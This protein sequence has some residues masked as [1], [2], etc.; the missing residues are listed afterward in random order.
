MLKY[1]DFQ[2]MS[3]IGAGIS[4][5]VFYGRDTITGIAFAQLFHPPLLRLNGSAYPG[6]K[7]HNRLDATGKTIAAYYFVRGLQDTHSRSIVHFL[8]DGSNRIGICDFFVAADPAR[9]RDAVQQQFQPLT[10][11]FLQAQL[12]HVADFMRQQDETSKKALRRAQ[13]VGTEAQLRISQHW[14]QNETQKKDEEALFA[15]QVQNGA[16]EQRS[17]HAARCRRLQEALNQKTKECWEQGLLIRDCSCPSPREEK[18]AGA[19]RGLPEGVL[20]EV[21]REQGRDGGDDGG[22]QGEGGVGAGDVEEAVAAL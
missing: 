9:R 2:E 3:P 4:A 16:V 18:G 14:L 7:Q 21:H 5:V 22:P 17:D 20:G 15:T 6:L 10:K 8:H 11:V 13:V 1:A 12:A 19:V